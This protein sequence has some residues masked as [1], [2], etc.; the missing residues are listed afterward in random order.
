MNF[1][2]AEIKI[3]SGVCLLEHPL[4]LFHEHRQ[5]ILKHKGLHLLEMLAQSVRLLCILKLNKEDFLTH[6]SHYSAGV[7]PIHH[8][9]ALFI[10]VL[11]LHYAIHT[12]YEKSPQEN[13]TALLIFICTCVLEIC[14]DFVALLNCIRGAYL[15]FGGFVFSMLITTRHF[16]LMGS[17]GEFTVG[18]TGY[19]I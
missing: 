16:K 8:H 5:L 13:Q 7:W 3:I 9:Q 19:E 11:V 2:D 12:D 17:F 15:K 10:P 18:I 1:I 6:F 4:G 14:M